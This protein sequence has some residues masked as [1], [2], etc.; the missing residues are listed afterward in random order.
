[1]IHLTCWI[2]LYFTTCIPIPFLD[3]SGRKEICRLR[4]VESFA[5][6]ETN[7]IFQR[8]GIK[9]SGKIM[10]WLTDQILHEHIQAVLGVH[11]FECWNHRKFA[12][13]LVSHA[14]VP[15]YIIN[16]LISLHD[17]RCVYIKWYT[18][19]SGTNLMST[20]NIHCNKAVLILLKF[21][22]CFFKVKYALSCLNKV[23]WSCN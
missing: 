9:F 6:R 20:F 7:I 17:W 16:V 1:M 22:V 12:F 2:K 5:I 13:W 21:C 3:V 11:Q 14:T 8:V 19:K 15:C 23:A 4:A 10:S 18:E